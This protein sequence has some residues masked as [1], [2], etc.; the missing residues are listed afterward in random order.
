MTSSSE[1]QTSAQPQIQN[2]SLETYQ[3][4]EQDKANIDAY[5]EAFF[6]AKQ[7]SGGMGTSDVDLV[8]SAAMSTDW[9]GSSPILP[10][11]IADLKALGP[12]HSPDRIREVIRT[13]AA[14]ADHY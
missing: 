11:T 1:T 13:F 9:S 5:H 14:L 7:V 2:T 8:I 6:V 10:Q 4:S 3:P 12:E